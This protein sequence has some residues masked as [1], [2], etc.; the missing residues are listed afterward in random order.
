MSASSASIPVKYTSGFS[1][2]DSRVGAE[3]NCGEYPASPGTGEAEDVNEYLVVIERERDAWGAY[4]PHLPGIGVVGDSREEV[5]EL[6]R[7]AISF[8]FDSL[9]EAGEPIPKP[10]AVGTTLVQVPAA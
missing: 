10:T 3:G 6:A 4:C 8:H 2:A 5:E 7:E 9:R 1:G